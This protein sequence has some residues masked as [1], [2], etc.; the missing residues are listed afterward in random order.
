MGVEK[1]DSAKK[2]Y[3]SGYLLYRNGNFEKAI[4][5][6]EKVIKYRDSPDHDNALFF[7]A[8]SFLNLG[9]AEKASKLFTSILKKQPENKAFHNAMGLCN[10]AL[11]QVKSA[12]ESFKKAVQIDPLY[13]EATYHLSK[14]CQAKK[15]FSASIQY[16]FQCQRIAPQSHIILKE[17]GTLY[18]FLGENKKA[19]TFLKKYAQRIPSDDESNLILA[20]LFKKENNIELSLQYLE[21]WVK[22]NPGHLRYFLEKLEYCTLLKRDEDFSK[23]LQE[24]CKEHPKKL[25]ML[26][27]NLELASQKKLYAYAQ[28]I[29][30]MQ[31]KSQQYNLHSLN[32]L[33][34]AQL[35]L[36]STPEQR[37][38]ILLL[39]EE[40]MQSHSSVCA[41]QERSYFWFL[42]GRH[43][44]F[45]MKP[46][47]ALQSYEKAEPLENYTPA[48]FYMGWIF[49]FDGQ[50]FKAR[51]MF[52]T[53]P[54][55]DFNFNNQVFDPVLCNSNFCLSVVNRILSDRDNVEKKWK[56]AKQEIDDHYKLF[57]EDLSVDYRLKRGIQ[58]P[59]HMEQAL[60]EFPDAQELIILSSFIHFLRGNEKKAELLIKKAISL[61][62]I[63]LFE[64]L[65]K[66]K[67][68]DKKFF[69]E[70]NGF[71][72]KIN[73]ERLR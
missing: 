49:L 27:R 12:E 2:F 17:I 48:R 3:K 35:M 10:L 39:G 73:P 32:T 69:M 24:F 15:E 19:I 33:L 42:N 67:L 45:L 13:F 72:E 57:K 64:H 9:K 70:F 4:D 16:L 66:I 55:A 47:E 43:K 65:V 50:I 1:L 62:K 18:A 22:K 5:C 30:Q 44:E 26:N 68:E 51:D 71:L 54:D 23:C 58:I 8:C 60:K 28:E 41:A 21:Q 36:N 34:E 53:N 11:G 25:L 20:L 56:K 7:K 6:F 38:D 37:L 40:F 29:A 31:V 46:L 14:V 59:A 61:G 63:A 52:S